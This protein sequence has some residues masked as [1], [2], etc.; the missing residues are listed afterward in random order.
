MN[1]YL[2]VRI[3]DLIDYIVYFF[4]PPV[5]TYLFFNKYK[6]WLS[7]SCDRLFVFRRVEYAL[8]L[9]FENSSEH[10]A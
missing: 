10:N 6:R 2:S 1:I 9:D 8:D 4:L 3:V 5:H 7:A